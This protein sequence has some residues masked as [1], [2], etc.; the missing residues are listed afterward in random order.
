MSGASPSIG[1]G[2][3][4]EGDGWEAWEGACVGEG[5]V[6]GAWV[7]SVLESSVLEE[8]A[9]VASVVWAQLEYGRAGGWT[10]GRLGRWGGRQVKVYCGA[11]HGRVRALVSRV[12]GG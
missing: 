4:T 2:R 7:R 12:Y 11:C 6:V 1:R 5:A 9:V 3:K 10:D 8:G